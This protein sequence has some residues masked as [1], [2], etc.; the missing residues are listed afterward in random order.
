MPISDNSTSSLIPCMGW[1][2]KVRPKA[3]A[4]IIAIRTKIH[5]EP[6][7]F[8]PVIAALKIVEPPPPR[9]GSTGESDIA[10]SNRGLVTNAYSLSQLRRIG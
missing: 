8:M 2:R 10:A 9:G 6:S 5:I 3:S 1:S 7:E 4:S